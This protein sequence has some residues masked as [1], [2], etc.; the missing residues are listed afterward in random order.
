MS[1]SIQADIIAQFASGAHPR[2]K[3]SR[4][5]LCLLA[6]IFADFII[7]A[8]SFFLFR[9]G[10]FATSI[11]FY[12]F[13]EDRSQ[14]SIYQ[15]PLDWFFVF[16]FALIAMC[17][18]TGHYTQRR[19]YWTHVH[20]I[21]RMVLMIA[22]VEGCWLFL[23]G[24]PGSPVWFLLTWGFVLVM[25]PIG[26][27]AVKRLLLHMGLWQVSTVII[28][29]GAG[30]IETYRTLSGEPTLGFDIQLFIDPGLDQTT[31]PEHLVIDGRSIPVV[32]APGDSLAFIR[33]LGLPHVVLALEHDQRDRLL[34]LVD[35]LSI[36]ANLVDVVTTFRGMPLYRLDASHIF[37]RD[38]LMLRVRNN[39]ARSAPRLLK[40]LADIVGSAILLGVLVPVLLFAAS[41]LYLRAGRP[42]FYSGR[43]IGYDGRPFGMLKFRTMVP[44]ADA[45]LE[46]WRR[47]QPVQYQQ[48]IDTGFKLRNDPRVTGVG[49]F[50]RRTSIDELPQLINVLRGDMSLVGPRPLIPLEVEPYGRD[51]D[52]YI[53]V[54]P[55]ITGLWQVS[56][57]SRNTFEERVAFDVWYIKNWSFWHD[58]VILM[59]TVNVL[60]K[61]DGAY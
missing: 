42:I 35:R 15:T 23:L 14:Y 24:H 36:Y 27:F 8:L 18:F 52:Q 41:V 16:S 29:T 55:G 40:R 31:V 61:R 11:V 12:M 25:L 58:L 1:T 38:L 20:A 46:H 32:Q 4:Y 51:Y 30:A 9:S 59:K 47:E 19:L 17:Y 22:V 10:E 2:L 7:L 49:R 3:I 57:R 60:I 56:G 13:N 6:H 53:R 21:T 33:A 54:R 45:V 34:A 26:R 44:N 50:L 43:R 39:L 48:Y 5:L 37:G 28:G